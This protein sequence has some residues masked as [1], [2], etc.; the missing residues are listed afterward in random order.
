[1]VLWERLQGT[2]M[3]TNNDILIAVMCKTVSGGLKDSFDAV[4]LY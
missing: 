2:G 3:R 4:L 1:M